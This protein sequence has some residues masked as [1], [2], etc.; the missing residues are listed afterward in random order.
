MSKSTV[1]IEQVAGD[2]SFLCRQ[3]CEFQRLYGHQPPSKAQT[4]PKSAANKT[5]R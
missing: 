2:P 1:F 5:R 4:K 3:W